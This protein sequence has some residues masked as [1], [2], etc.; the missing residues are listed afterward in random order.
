MT[1]ILHTPIAL[2][3]RFE[4]EQTPETYAVP[5]NATASPHND[6]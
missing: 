2:A 5:P 4:S 3:S 1:V 6:G